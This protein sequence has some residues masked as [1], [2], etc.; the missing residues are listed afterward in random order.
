MRA[1]GEEPKKRPDQVPHPL[2]GI[3][4]TAWREFLRVY[5][6]RQPS[7]GGPR[8][9]DWSAVVERLKLR[10]FWT[11]EIEEKIAFCEREL[12]ALE[13]RLAEEKDKD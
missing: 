13:A 12:V 10:G 3:N 4:S 9:L 1:R 7:F 6:C 5:T 11:I 8:F 2:P